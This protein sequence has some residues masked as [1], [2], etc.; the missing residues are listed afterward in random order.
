MHLILALLIKSIQL[1]PLKVTTKRYYEDRTRNERKLQRM[2][3]A[4]YKTT[5]NTVLKL[6]SGGG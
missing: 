3:T 2:T 5:C 6:C 4:N 1:M